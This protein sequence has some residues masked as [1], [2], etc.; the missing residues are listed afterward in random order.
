MYIC[1]KKNEYAILNVKFE[2]C[3]KH[4]TDIRLIVSSFQIRMDDEHNSLTFVSSSR[5]YEKIN[6]ID[7]LSTQSLKELERDGWLSS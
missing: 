3:R 2:N 1:A 5:F 7:D 6:F 4:R